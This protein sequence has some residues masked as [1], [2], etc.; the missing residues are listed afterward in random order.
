[1]FGSKRR[2]VQATV[3]V[4]APVEVVW[5]QY[6][7]RD[8]FLQWAP[9]V[10]AVEVIGGGAKRIGARVQTTMRMGPMKQRMN[11]EIVRYDSP[12]AVTLRGR[13]PGWRYDM[14]LELEAEAGGTR[15]TYACISD[16][17][18][19]VRVFAPLLDKMNHG[20]LTEALAALKVAAERAVS[21]SSA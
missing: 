19:P 20:M 1:M 16:Y 6:D 18:L 17:A 13:M 4:N 14:A 10:L 2:E 3:F 15:C 7:D 12:R 11:E 21:T 5:R 8:A 9:N